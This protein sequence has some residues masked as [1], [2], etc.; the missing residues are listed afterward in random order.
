LLDACTRAVTHGSCQPAQSELDPS[1]IRAIAVVSWRSPARAEVQVGLKEGKRNAWLSRELTFSESDARLER[2]RAV[3]LTIATL[4]GELTE[5][6]PEAQTSERTAGAKPS[7]PAEANAPEKPAQPL[8]R[9][10]PPTAAGAG[11]VPAQSKASADAF[12]TGRFFSLETGGLV[13]PGLRG[14]AWRVGPYLRLSYDLSELPIYAHAD[15]SY[16][17]LLSA[18]EPRMTWLSV[19]LG[20]GAFLAVGAARLELEGAGLMRRTGASAR[21]PATGAEDS[22]GEWMP[23]LGAAARVGWP[24]H[25]QFSLTGGVEGSVLLRGIRVTNAGQDVGSVPPVSWAVSGGFRVSWGP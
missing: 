15:L 9:A 14:G 2:W 23:G 19:G 5:A 21:H 16:A 1:A 4:V 12:A 6:Q 25:R 7:E 13:G 22:G 24:A 8:S 3:G 20:A 18:A 11:P 10:Q 17:V